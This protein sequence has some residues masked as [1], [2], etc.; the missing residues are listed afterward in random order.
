MPGTPARRAMCSI[1]T[2]TSSIS[3]PIAAAMPPS[4][5]M[6]KVMPR[7]ESSSTVISTD[8]GT[9]I[10]ATSVTRQLRRN[11]SITSAAN[12]SPIRIASSSAAIEERTSSVWSYHLYSSIE[13]GWVFMKASSRCCTS[14]ARLSESA[15]SCWYTS[16]VTAGWPLS[17]TS[18]H[19]GTV[20][21]VTLAMSPS[22]RCRLT[23]CAALHC[24]P[25]RSS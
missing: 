8:S 15:L 18:I 21:I 11:A 14:L 16:K 19:C 10:I 5:M 3:R 13:P 6:L 24:V 23:R 2:M 9:T 12:T 20:P 1:I 4:V 7:T 22:A 17:S 25:S